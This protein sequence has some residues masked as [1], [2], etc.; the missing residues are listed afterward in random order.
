MKFLVEVQISTDVGNATLKDGTMTEQL[1]KYLSD[2]KPEAVYFAAANGQRT[3][4]LVLD[5]QNRDNLTEIVELLWLD[6][7]AEIYFSPVMTAEDFEKAAP[8]LEKVIEARK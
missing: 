5:M 1:Q 7:R 8:T 3:I 2:V 4:Y 6:W